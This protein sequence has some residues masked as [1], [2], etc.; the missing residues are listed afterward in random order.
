MKTKIFKSHFTDKLKSCIGFVFCCLDRVRGFIPFKV[1]SS[2]P[3]WIRTNSTERMPICNSKFKMFFHSFTSNNFFRVI[4]FKRQRIIRLWTLKFNFVNSF[5][6]F[7]THFYIVC[8]LVYSVDFF[9]NFHK[10]PHTQI[11]FLVE[12]MLTRDHLQ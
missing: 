12:D 6:I 7:F 10:H 8:Y 11:Y 1:L 2:R 5:V 4:I 9:S 3:K